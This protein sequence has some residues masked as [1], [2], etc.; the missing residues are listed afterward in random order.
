M[1]VSKYNSALLATVVGEMYEIKIQEQAVTQAL[2]DIDLCK[3]MV[4]R[5]KVS[6][7]DPLVKLLALQNQFTL[8]AYPVSYHYDSFGN[9]RH[10]LENKLCFNYTNDATESEIGRGGS[11][12]S[13]FT[14]A[15]IDWSKSISN[16]AR[17]LQYQSVGGQ[18]KNNEK[19]TRAKWVN[20]FGSKS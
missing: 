14:F 15:L 9:G 6:T 17:R 19:L 7:R 12:G 2:N 3:Q 13:Q 5:A 11:G 20:M 10:S 8:V 16:S 4:D 1:T 18:L